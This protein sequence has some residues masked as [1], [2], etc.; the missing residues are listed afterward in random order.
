MG[1]GGGKGGMKGGRG[2]DGKRE[3]GGREGGR[4]GNSSDVAAKQ[5]FQSLS[6]ITRSM[7][8]TVGGAQAIPNPMRIH[9]HEQWTVVWVGN[10][11]KWRR[12]VSA[13]DHLRVLNLQ[14]CA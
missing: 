13:P 2:R 10:Q 14:T 11:T 12:I 7:Q 8:G 5:I 9:W 1:E 3:G 4:E 6:Y